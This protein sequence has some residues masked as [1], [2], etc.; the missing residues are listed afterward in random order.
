MP[1]KYL[2]INETALRVFE[3]LKMLLLKSSISYDE[4]FEMLEQKDDFESIYTTETLAKYFNT[5]KLLGFEIEKQK[6][7]GR[8]YLK[9]FPIKIDF[10]LKDLRVMATLEEYVKAI[11]SEKIGIDFGVVL[12]NL[13]KS[14]SNDTVLRLKHNK[15]SINA[16]IN[17]DFELIQ[18]SELVD[19][20]EKYCTDGL[21]LKISYKNE[22]ENL[23][24]YHTVDPKAVFYKN[25]NLFL[26]S[27]NPLKSKMQVFLLKNVVE[28]SQTP[29][30]ISRSHSPQ[31]TVFEVKNGL[32]KAYKMRP[33]ERSLMN[34]KDSK[35]RVFISSSHEDCNVLFNRLL[36]YQLNCE[37]HQPK[38]KRDEYKQFVD[39]VL[40]NYG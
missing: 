10:S 31:T 24:E 29:Q 2:K 21:R 26:D 23:V 22:N 12:R 38:G 4:L 19:K 39:E 35:E 30:K 36:K 34:F 7:D 6:T 14:F 5:F 27:F 15:E 32:R 33:N 18:Y 20:F 40:A 16:S 17:F 1:E 8:Y 28:V 11:N 13:Q 25:H 3:V 37:I 9:S